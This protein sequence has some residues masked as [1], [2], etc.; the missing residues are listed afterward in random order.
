MA[1]DF[2]RREG[3]PITRTPANI[4]PPVTANQPKWGLAEEPANTACAAVVFT[5]KVA[6]V[7]SPLIDTDGKAVGEILRNRASK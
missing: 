3:T 4:P 1:V 7:L 6:V 5:V 2:R